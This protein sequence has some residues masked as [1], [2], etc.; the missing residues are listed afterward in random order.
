MKEIQIINSNF[1]VVVQELEQA[2]KEGYSV[3]LE[4]DERPMHT[5]MGSFYV[6]LK[7]NEIP[8]VQAEEKAVESAQ[9]KRGRPASK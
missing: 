7:K 4:G 6:T 1:I 8:V 3:V 9:A 5:I 2:I